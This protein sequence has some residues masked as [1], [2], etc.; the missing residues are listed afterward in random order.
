MNYA[1]VY[2]LYSCLRTLSQSSKTKLDRRA[3]KVYNRMI[4]SSG[5]KI[6]KL[7]STLEK[8]PSFRLVL[9]F[10]RDPAWMKER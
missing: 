6:F 9:D 5:E 3:S 4:S 10:V 1:C 2:M 7:D 8:Y